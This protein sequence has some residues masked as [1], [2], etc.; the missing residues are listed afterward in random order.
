MNYSRA[1]ELVDFHCPHLLFVQNPPLWKLG[2][3]GWIAPGSGTFPFFSFATALIIFSFDGLS[4][5]IWSYV[6]AGGKTSGSIGA[7]L[8]SGSSKCSSIFSDVGWGLLVPSLFFT[9]HNHVSFLV[10][11]YT[12]FIFFC[13]AGCSACSGRLS[14]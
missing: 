9:G 6:S 7:R 11:S 4:V 1:A 3:S 14:T 13:L 10:T 5:L 12:S 8:V 2:V